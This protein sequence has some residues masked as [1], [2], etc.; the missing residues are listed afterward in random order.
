MHIYPHFLP[1]GRRFLYVAIVPE[2]DETVHELWAGELGSEKAALVSRIG[3]RVEY[4]E[5]G[6]LFSVHEGSLFA[7]KFDAETLKFSGE[8]VLIS[9]SLYYFYGPATAG[10]SVSSAGVLACEARQSPTRLAWLDRAGK[11]T[12]VLVPEGDV[13]EVR[14]STDGKRLA[15]GVL[16][17]K[18]GTS[19]VWVYELARNVST[20]LTLGPF[21]DDAP[22]WSPDGS[23][24]AF[25]SD[26]HG[27]PDLYVIDA[28]SPGSEKLLL[29]PEGA[30]QTESWS[31]DGRFLAYTESNRTTGDDI[32]LL[33]V[34]GSGKPIPYLRSRFEEFDPR[35]SPDG[36]WI[37]YC[38]DESGTTEVYVSPR[39]DPGRRTRVSTGGGRGPRWRRDGR[40]LYYLGSDGNLMAVP[41]GPGAEAGLPA[42]LFRF[43]SG[44]IDFDVAPAGDRFIATTPV[45]VRPAPVQVTLGWP[46]LL[47]KLQ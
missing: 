31:P 21:N 3:S 9:D 27:P 41:L 36:R 29:A 8:P 43:V 13:R 16:D 34:G 2:K 38:T 25:R 19:D 20:R 35:F 28:A 42:A 47:R 18:T 4:A 12:S 24:I 17:R 10:F 14:L 45:G 37:A 11:E 7:R 23:Q 33:P 5:P 22:V 30:Q 32:W 15:T 44:V 40:E 6:Y 39:D 46:A 1:D 26:R